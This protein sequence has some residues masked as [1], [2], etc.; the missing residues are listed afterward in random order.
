MGWVRRSMTL[1][2]ALIGIIVLLLLIP[3]EMVEG[4]I[5]DREWTKHQV[6]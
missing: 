3:L 2:V 6:E 1:R 5:R 4:L